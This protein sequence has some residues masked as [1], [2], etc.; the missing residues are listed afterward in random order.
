MDTRSREPEPAEGSSPRRRTVIWTVVTVLVLAGV[1]FAGMAIRGSRDDSG[2]VQISQLPPE[3]VS[4]RYYDDALE[5]LASGD[6]SSAVDLLQ[7]ALELDPGNQAARTELRRITSQ[8]DAD[9]G[10]GTPSG[11][12]Q[13]GGSTEP[14]PEPDPDDFLA[15]ISDMTKLLPRSA[16]GYAL[17]MPVSDKTDAAISGDPTVEGPRAEV[18]TV[19]FSVHDRKDANGAASFITKVSRTVYPKD[20]GTVEVEGTD[21]YF[22]TDG[23]RLATVVYVRGRY[24]FEVIM[25]ANSGTAKS[26]KAL[27]AKA[28]ESFPD[29]M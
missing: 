8:A 13:S 26:L 9:G 12:G 14:T 24:V 11:G 15:A 2:P 17:G 5:A 28:A 6:T 4:Q 19:L 21:A 25:T 7:R 22:G 3:E 23:K 27:A 20:Q 16:A 29:E 1:V 10:G 18:S